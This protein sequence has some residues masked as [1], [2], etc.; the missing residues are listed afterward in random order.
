MGGLALGGIGEV[1]GGGK[2]GGNG[3]GNGGGAHDGDFAE[4]SIALLLEV[5]RLL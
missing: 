2:R 4:E 3:E 1:R 5:G